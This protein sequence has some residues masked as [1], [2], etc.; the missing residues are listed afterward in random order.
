MAATADS[1]RTI[2]ML[3]IGVAVWIA[4]WL[5]LGALCF[6]EVRGLSSLSDTMQV[7]GQSLQEAGDGLDAIA[8]LPLVGAG[9]DAAA[10]KVQDLAGRTVAEAEDSRTHITRLSVLALLIGGVVPILMGICIYLPLRRSL[11][12]GRRDQPTMTMPR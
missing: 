1:Q 10:T 12:R 9:I 2:R 5:V 6:I 4:V 7:A 8:G 11:T 3:D